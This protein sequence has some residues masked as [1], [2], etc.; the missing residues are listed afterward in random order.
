MPRIVGRMKPGN[1]YSR[2]KCLKTE[3]TLQQELGET[4]M[5]TLTKPE[6][7]PAAPARVILRDYASLPEAVALDAIRATRERLRQKFP[8]YDGY[9]SEMIR[10]VGL[11]PADPQ[12]SCDEY[13]EA[14]YV[15]A[16]HA[17]FS[18]AGKNTPE[19]RPPTVM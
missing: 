17:S 9:Q 6:T 12:I 2:P 16:K 1:K 8:D 5:D 14:M 10:L 3:R 4:T 11:F 15:L 7:S 19:D 18:Q 13:V